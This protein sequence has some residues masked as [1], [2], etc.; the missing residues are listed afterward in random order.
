MK[1]ILTASA[2]SMAMA[3]SAMAAPNDNDD[4]TI[5]AT[6]EKECSIEDITVLDLGALPIVET[7]GPDA[8]LLTSAE[9]RAEQLAW[10]SCNFTNQMTL[11]TPTPLTSSSASALVGTEEPGSATFSNTIN[12]RFRANN[13]ATSPEANS[14]GTATSTRQSSGP[15]HKQ[16]RF[17]AIVDGDDNAGIRPIAAEDYTATA[18]VEITTL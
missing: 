14:F 18:T 17:R 5:N 2:I 9:T 11:G 7:P 15:I 6:V 1:K 3:T 12:Y 8:L 13:Y 4:V 16:I 10:V